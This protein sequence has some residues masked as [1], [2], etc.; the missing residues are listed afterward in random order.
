MLEER[1]RINRKIRDELRPPSLPGQ[2]SRA[3]ALWIRS[4]ES[5]T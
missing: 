3:P 2:L 1:I 5:C 4:A